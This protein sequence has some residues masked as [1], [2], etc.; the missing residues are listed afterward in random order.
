[1]FA[2]VTVL[3]CVAVCYSEL[4][5]APGDVLQPLTTD[6]NLPLKI[7]TQHTSDLTATLLGCQCLPISPPSVI[8]GEER[9]G[10]KGSRLRG[11]GKSESSSSDM[12]QGMGASGT[13]WGGGCKKQVCF[14]VQDV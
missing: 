12:L 6:N 1:M 4:Q 5:R 10:D 14:L 13:L 7:F 2:T 8:G 3:Q 11:V 9:W